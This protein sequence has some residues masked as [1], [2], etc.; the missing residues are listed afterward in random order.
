MSTNILLKKDGA[1]LVQRAACQIAHLLALY[2]SHVYDRNKTAGPSA[3]AAL[4]ATTNVGHGMKSEVPVSAM[5][6]FASPSFSSMRLLITFSR[7]V[8]SKRHRSS[9]VGIFPA[10]T[11]S[12][13][14]TFSLKSIY[15]V[16]HSS[17]DYQ[18][19][20]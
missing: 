16:M 6:A 2:P 5:L 7:I 12:T 18:S 15:F 9:P 8:A 1:A 4:V 14:K 20:T 3:L 17:T 19:A 11:W 10:I 13:L